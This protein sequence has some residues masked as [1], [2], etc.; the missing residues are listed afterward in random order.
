M[1]DLRHKVDPGT[2]QILRDVHEAAS[3]IG[4]KLLLIGAFARD[5]WLR[6]VHEL[7]AGRATEDYDLAVLIPTWSHYDEMRQVLIDSGH[8]EADPDQ[9]QRLVAGKL[10]VDL[11]PFG[12]LET[13]PGEVSW[14]P[15]GAIEMSTLGLNEALT[16]G[17][18]VQMADE[19]VVNV[20]SL[21][22][23]AMLK[24]I[25]W[26]DRKAAKD[27]YDVMLIARRYADAGHRDRL[28]D[29][30]FELLEEFSDYELA[31]AAF[32]GIDIRSIARP[33]TRKPIQAA[34]EAAINYADDGRFISAAIDCLGDYEDRE[35]RATEI[36]GAVLRGVV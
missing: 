19:F 5:L 35:Q 28:L 27:A 36:L 22:A 11:V 26:T 24:M 33:E 20:A 17:I 18:Q 14:P 9:R 6:L 34:L 10:K 4:V 29:E 23:L 13:H 7:P 8:Y 31:G 30:R 1:L 3:K 21:S 12:G 25:A 2:L 16:H 32:L 15:E